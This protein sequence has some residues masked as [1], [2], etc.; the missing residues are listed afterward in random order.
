MGNAKRIAVDTKER[1]L[2]AAEQLFGDFGFNA[3]SLRDITA[4][5]GVNLASVNYHFGSK[6]ALLA[7]V[8]ERR[9]APVNQRRLERL[10]EVETS[11]D[12]GRSQV[13]R[14]IRAFVGPPF[15]ML[16]EWGDGGR[17]FLRLAG[18]IHSETDE[19]RAAM[20]KKYEPVFVRF[21]TALQQ[22]LPD[23][24]LDEVR[25]G[26]LFV[27]GSMAHTM[28]WGETIAVQRGMTRSPD[29]MLESLVQF[30]T[31]GMARPSK[32]AVGVRADTRKV[33][34]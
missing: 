23:V 32:L 8:F 2:D 17:K 9:F 12:K 7:A 33:N 19:I 1:I 30:T 4:E 34:G 27:V 3:T 13:E 14:I 20:V 31:A 25:L 22:A 10:S 28:T 21:T 11:P 15:E 26:F 5:A 18:R 29:D 16:G 6:E 24:D